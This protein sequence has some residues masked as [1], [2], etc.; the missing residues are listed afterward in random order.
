LNFLRLASSSLIKAKRLELRSKYGKNDPTST[1]D[2][3]STRG[4]GAVGG[5]DVVDDTSSSTVVSTNSRAIGSI[6]V[7]PTTK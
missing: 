3:S 7:D 4:D 5:G 6:V 2:A 1:D